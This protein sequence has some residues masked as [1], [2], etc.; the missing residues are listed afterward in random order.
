MEFH[1]KLQE[2]RKRRGLTQEAL[3][4]ALFVSRTAVSKWESGRGYPSI[5]SLKALSR[6]FGITVDELLSGEELL[7]LA[8][9]DTRQARGRVY[10][11]LSGLLDCSSV[12][13]LFLPLFAQRTDGLVRPVSLL[14]LTGISPWLR[15]TY[16][17]LVLGLAAWGMVTLALQN[18]WTKAKPRISL[19]LNTL[20]ALLCIISLQPYAAVC[21]L[22]FLAIKVAVLTKKP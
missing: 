10:D 18:C 11:L 14:S 21:L 4:Q 12:L 19:L 17:A 22:L 20:A 13:L 2:L 1:E 16:F 9:E 3:A 5:D 6:F 15:G 7:T 8:Q